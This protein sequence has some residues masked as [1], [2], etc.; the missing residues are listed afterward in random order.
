MVSP[1]LWANLE[2]EVFF[3]GAQVGGR[4]WDLLDFGL[5]SL[6]SSALDHS[7]TAPPSSWGGSLALWCK[8]KQ[9]IILG[10]RKNNDFCLS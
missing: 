1:L 4:T 3:K 2:V 7:A 10:G 5:F 9:K 8:F 6:T